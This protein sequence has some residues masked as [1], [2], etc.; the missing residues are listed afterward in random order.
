MRKF[1]ML[2][3]TKHLVNYVLLILHFNTFSIE[4]FNSEILL[5][6]WKKK[7]QDRV[8]KKRKVFKGK[9]K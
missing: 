6:P 9:R 8:K 7:L 2:L 1:Y 3:Y 4:E 5:F